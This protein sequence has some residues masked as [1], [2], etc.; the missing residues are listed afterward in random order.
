M[1]SSVLLAVAEFVL[2]FMFGFGLLTVLS[3]RRK[4]P[5]DRRK[6]ES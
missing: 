3:Y 4:G 5:R 1:D 2:G 6:G